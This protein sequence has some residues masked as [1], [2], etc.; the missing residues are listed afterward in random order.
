MSRL[1]Q[2]QVELTTLLSKITQNDR[3]V[4]ETIAIFCEENIYYS[5]QITAITMSRLGMTD[6]S[7]KI[8]FY[9]AI[10]SIIKNVRGEYVQLFEHKLTQH[11]P[12]DMHTVG[13]RS[14]TLKKKYL[15]LFLSWEACLNIA[16]LRKM[17]EIYYKISHDVSPCLNPY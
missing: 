15:I 6:P 10:D 1:R 14:T 5:E 8:N 7:Q 13:L 4:F 11:F 16:T 9:Y 17:L 2:V 3:K 12:R